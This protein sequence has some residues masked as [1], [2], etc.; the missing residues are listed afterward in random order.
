MKSFNYKGT[1]IYDGQNVIIEH[2]KQFSTAG[3]TF[4]SPGKV[5][6]EET[7]DTLDRVALYLFNDVLDGAF[8][9]D[10][11]KQGNYKNS[12]WA[13]SYIPAR[14][15]FESNSTIIA[16]HAKSIDAYEII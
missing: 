15:T 3:K 10:R 2:Y 13:A 7:G 8:P 12:W 11:T 1:T 9:D 5:H 16:I 6:I 4:F 14:K